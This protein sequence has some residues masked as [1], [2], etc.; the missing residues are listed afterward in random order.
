MKV[1]HQNHREALAILEAHGRDFQGQSDFA[2]PL[3]LFLVTLKVL[4]GHLLVRA[5]RIQILN[6]VQAHLHQLMQFVFRGGQ[7][8]LGNF[9]DDV[10]LHLVNW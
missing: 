8:L 6:L 2:A 9:A 1:Q 4:F 10:P 5:L 7:I 3:H